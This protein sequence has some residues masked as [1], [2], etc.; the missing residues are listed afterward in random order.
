MTCLDCMALG[1]LHDCAT[2]SLFL[3]LFTV[4]FMMNPKSALHCAT[5]RGVGTSFWRHE[6]WDRLSNSQLEGWLE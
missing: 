1:G 3:G 4:N 5:A 6:P 2:C